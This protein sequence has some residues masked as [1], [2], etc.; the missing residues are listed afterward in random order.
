MIAICSQNTRSMALLRS[1]NLQISCKPF[2]S[3]DFLVVSVTC[4]VYEPEW[5]FRL[6]A[7]FR[8]NSTNNAG[9]YWAVSS[10]TSHLVFS[11]RVFPN[12]KPVFFGYFLLPEIRFFSTTK[13]GCFKN[14]GIAV[15]FKYCQF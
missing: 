4:F 6:N 2:I 14:P 12:S 5:H 10:I 15:A 13:P 8:W 9:Y 3:K 1:S 7:D 11:T